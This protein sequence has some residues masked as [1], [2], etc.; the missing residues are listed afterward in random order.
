MDMKSFTCSLA[1]CVALVSCEKSAPIT[2]PLSSRA[3]PGT[4]WRLERIDTVGG[5]SMP[6]LAADTIL[7][8]FD[9]GRHFSGAG[10]GLCANTYFGVYSLP[11]GDSLHMDT[12]STTKMG[13][14]P[15]SLYGDYWR[16]L[17]K[18]DHYQGPDGQL[19]IYC[20]QK[21][22]RLVFRQVQ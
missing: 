22:R 14:R 5:G 9:D 15:G 8:A 13:C 2:E 17:W 6:L 19:S 11:S 1:M 21:S 12:I 3:L 4:S 20:D 18:A 10:H 7:L 16:L